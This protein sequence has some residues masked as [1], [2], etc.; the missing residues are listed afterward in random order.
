MDFGTDLIFGLMV[1][2]YKLVGSAPALL[3]NQK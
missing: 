2:D 3:F 1:S